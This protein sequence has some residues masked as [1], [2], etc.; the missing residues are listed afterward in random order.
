MQNIQKLLLK[1]WRDNHGLM[2]FLLLMVFFRSAV[3]DWNHVPTGSMVPTII[4]GDR[5]FINKL[6]YD[7]RVPFTLVSLAKLGDPE[8]G[9]IIVFESAA[10]ELRLIKRVIGVPGDIIAMQDNMLFVNG[11]ELEYR[12]RK[13]LP[14]T[15][16]GAYTAEATEVLQP[17]VEYRIRTR[18]NTIA[19]SFNAVY[20]PEGYYF[21]LGDSRDNSADSRYIGL[22]PRHEIIGRSRSVVMSLDRDNFY[23]PKQGRFFQ[24]L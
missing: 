17:G 23:L 15:G 3:A 11:R 6:A 13:L 8:P 5:V 20:V 7:V 22:V 19:G 10:A 18:S 9:D 24:Q 12:D 21:V 2:A 16:F 4:E 1:L 14:A